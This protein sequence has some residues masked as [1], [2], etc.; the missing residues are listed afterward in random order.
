MK[1]AS[2]SVDSRTLTELNKEIEYCQRLMNEHYDQN[3]QPMYKSWPVDAQALR[4]AMGTFLINARVL[5]AE[6]ARN[7]K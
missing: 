2:T 7:T 4:N 5:L 6:L 1:I 3:N